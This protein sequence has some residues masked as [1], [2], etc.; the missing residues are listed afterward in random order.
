MAMGVLIER[1][2][3]DAAAARGEFADSFAEFASAEQRRLVK[4]TF[5]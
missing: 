5:S 1:L 3:R 4:D 2:E